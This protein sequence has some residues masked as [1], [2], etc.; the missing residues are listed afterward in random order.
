MVL[1]ETILGCPDMDS[2]KSHLQL[3]HPGRALVNPIGWDAILKG[4]HLACT[5]FPNRH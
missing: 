5:M 3:T 2:G 4:V 1:L